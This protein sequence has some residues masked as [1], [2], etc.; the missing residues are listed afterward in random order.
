M[1]DEC[2]GAAVEL[3]ELVDGF[4]VVL[5]LIVGEVSFALGDVPVGGF[6]GG[7]V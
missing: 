7:W 3:M 5:V 6:A 2:W 1:G 4:L